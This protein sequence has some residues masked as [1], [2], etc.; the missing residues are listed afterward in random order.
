VRKDFACFQV[1]LM[2]FG[3]FRTS[4]S[5]SA[6]RGGAP[7]GD[8]ISHTA[9]HSNAYLTYDYLPNVFARLMSHD[10]I[11]GNRPRGSNVFTSSEVLE[12]GPRYGSTFHFL[13]VVTAKQ[14]TYT[15]CHSYSCIQ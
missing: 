3:I 14:K 9:V 7:S 4:A 6:H 15:A 5:S 2:N 11:R 12:Q 13:S 1:F 10:L 8:C